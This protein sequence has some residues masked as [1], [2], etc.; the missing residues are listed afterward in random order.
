ML[1]DVHAVNTVA[2]YQ[3][4]KLLANWETGELFTRPQQLPKLVIC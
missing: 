3:S 4:V 2:K 1:S